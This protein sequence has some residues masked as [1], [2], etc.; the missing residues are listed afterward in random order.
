MGRGPQPEIVKWPLPLST[1][2]HHHA[3]ASASLVREMASLPF[4]TPFFRYNLRTFPCLY[5]LPKLPPLRPPGAL[6]PFPFHKGQG[7]SKS[8]RNEDSDQVKSCLCHSCPGK[9]LQPQTSVS[10]SHGWLCSKPSVN[11]V[12]A[13]T[14]RG[15]ARAV[16]W[17][18]P[19]RKDL[20]PSWNVL[21]S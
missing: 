1:D 6:C 4:L 7:V 10:S 3:S 16:A 18:G 19:C 20:C 15:H 11:S 14:G 9:S 17:W 12:A 21:V 5:N 8:W 13:V 2:L